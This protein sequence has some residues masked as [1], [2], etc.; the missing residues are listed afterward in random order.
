MKVRIKPKRTTN[1]VAWYVQ[2]KKGLFWKD[3]DHFYK[4][5]GAID[6]V[7][8]LKKSYEE[9]Q[10]LNT[11]KR[12]SFNV[13]GV[14]QRSFISNGYSDR[15]ELHTQ[16]PYIETDPAKSTKGL[17]VSGSYT[18]EIG[19]IKLKDWFG[20]FVAEPKLFRITIEEIS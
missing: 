1:Q 10:K 16:M 7:N 12:K 3:L 9:N 5:D 2:I 8:N 15:I 19:Y 11:T 20:E 4:L 17:W 13:Y 14:R 6:L 18:N